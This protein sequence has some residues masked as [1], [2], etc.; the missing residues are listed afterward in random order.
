MRVDRFIATRERVGR[1]QQPER[2]GSGFERAGIMRDGKGTADYA[3]EAAA[4]VRQKASNL[5][6]GQASPSRKY[7]VESGEEGGR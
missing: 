1:D 2:V 3:R 7:V 5:A 4:L 6:R